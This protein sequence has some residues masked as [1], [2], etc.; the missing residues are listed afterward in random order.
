MEEMFHAC[1]TLLLTLSRTLQNSTAGRAD[2]EIEAEV[3]NDIFAFGDNMSCS[4]AISD[5]G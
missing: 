4:L 3:F 5:H 2:T 1:Q